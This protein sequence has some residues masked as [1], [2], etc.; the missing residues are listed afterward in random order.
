[1]LDVKKILI[2]RL[3]SIGDILLTTAFIRQVRNKYPNARLTYIVKKEFQSL[4]S[5]NPHI[6]KII[7]FDSAT[8]ISGLKDLNR[9]V[10]KEKFDLVFDLHN[11]LRTNRL[12]AG[13][14]LAYISKIKKSKIKRAVLVFLKIN[15]YKTIKS[16][17]E[18]YL[19]VGKKF[20]IQD[21]GQ[22]L[23]LFLSTKKAENNLEI[24]KK[25]D[26]IPGRYIC[27]GP[28][29]AHFTK[30]WPIENYQKLIKKISE[31]TDY[32]IAILGS[33]Q[34]KGLLKEIENIKNAVELTG[35]L[36]LLESASIIKESAGL[37]CNDS[38]LMHMAAALKK[39]VVAIFGSTVRELGFFPY[40]ADAAIIENDLWCRPCSHVGRSKC[41]LGHFKCM[42]LISTA[43]VFEE[44]KTK[45]V[46]K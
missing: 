11:N 12:L 29:A 46:V 32:K 44:V 30:M 17:P 45:L 6:N 33:P 36:N 40:R 37:I 41:P 4:L 20:G 8:K 43:R 42:R 14:K 7:A 23:E 31:E 2:L 38:G 9:I 1:M 28:G 10:Q 3:S 19:E 34:E 39:P 15:L 22:G 16:I 26:L 18:R 5:H 25:Y 24:L 13:L 35:E 21:D 27:I